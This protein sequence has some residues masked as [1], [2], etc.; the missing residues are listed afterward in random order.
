MKTLLL[1]TATKQATIAVVVDGE[2]RHLC[3]GYRSDGLSANLVPMIDAALRE[4]GVSPRELDV[5]MVANGPGSF[6][7]IRIGV[8]VAKTMAWG[9]KVKVVPISSLELMAAV[10]AGGATDEAGD[11]ADRAGGAADEAGKIGGT[12]DE[13]RYV[14]PLIDA[15]RGYVFAGLYDRELNPVIPDAYVSLEE[16][17]QKAGDEVQYVSYDTFDFAVEEPGCE[18]LK[19]VDKH[20]NDAGVNPHQLN[21]NYLKKTE[22]EERLK[23]GKR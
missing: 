8:T 20:K 6:T 21:P 12:G 13:K 3:T 15:R 18:I 17:R 14:A 22:A 23:E 4:S 9:L 1:N 2:V 19:V 10:G 5:I 7:G 16:F 11:V